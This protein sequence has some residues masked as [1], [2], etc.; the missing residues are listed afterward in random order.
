MTANK[1][2][3]GNSTPQPA[4][5]VVVEAP[6]KGPAK[7][8]T[9]VAIADVRLATA[10]DEKTPDANRAAI[11]DV[12]RHGYQK[13]L[14]QDPKNKA[15]MLGLARYYSRVGEHEKAMETYQ[16]YLTM[17]PTDRE[18]TYEVARMF[19]RWQDWNN[20]VAWCDR[21][22][23]LDPENLSFRKT[24]AFC[25][26]CSGRWEEAFA[27]FLTIMPE[28]QA[29]YTIARVLEG[30]NYPDAARQQLQLAVQADPNFADARE[31]LAEMDQPSRPIGAVDPGEI[32]RT[33]YVPEQ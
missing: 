14:Q 24:K 3:F 23:K 12:A 20:A 25:Q 4:A 19:A 18:V 1:P 17:N 30:Q 13:A 10:L 5:E 31:Y 27:V 32:Q 7:P 22:L 26:A 9:E 28:S 11:L 21:A 33:G 15:A 6:R 16:K 8:E 2:L 29:R